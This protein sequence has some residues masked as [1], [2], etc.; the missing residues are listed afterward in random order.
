MSKK[1]RGKKIQVH[2]IQLCN[3][4][5]RKRKGNRMPPWCSAVFAPA[6]T[7]LSTSKGELYGWEL[8]SFCAIK[9]DNRSL[10]LGFSEEC[11]D[12][13]VSRKGCLL[14]PS[15]EYQNY[16]PE[17]VRYQK[18]FR[19]TQTKGVGGRGTREEGR[20]LFSMICIN[21]PIYPSGTIFQSAFRME[22]FITMLN[23][24]PDIPISTRN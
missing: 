16:V 21:H 24:G 5:N 11:C 23:C 2:W 1:W 6:V 9:N 14:S 15:K 17:N 7:F 8:R 13:N 20:G 10:F 12:G 4:I 22:W 19:S 18:L 3:E